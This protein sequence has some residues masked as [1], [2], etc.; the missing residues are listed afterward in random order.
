MPWESFRQLP[1]HPA[2]RYEYRGE[3]ALIS[4]RPHYLHC[5]RET[6][7]AANFTEG[8]AAPELPD[9]LPILKSLGLKLVRWDQGTSTGE[10]KDS[11]LELFRESFSQSAPFCAL[12][13]GMQDAATLDL[14]GGSLVGGSGYPV[15]D[16]SFAICEEESDRP[17][18]VIQVTLVSPGDW[19]DFTDSNWQVPVPRDPLKSCWGHAHLT[20][21]FISPRWQRRGLGQVL[22][23]NSLSSLKSLG[24]GKLFSTFLLGDHASM[25]WHWKQ[26]FQ[27]LPSISGG[28]FR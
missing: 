26:G 21:I 24:Y 9:S 22:L 1:R 6:N 5:W 11:L 12:D 8:E 25:L 10:Q 19:S 27:L 20:W 13:Q 7:F 2:Y 28:R 3:Q 17:V 4:G 14:L 15:N 23:M 16:S 18:A